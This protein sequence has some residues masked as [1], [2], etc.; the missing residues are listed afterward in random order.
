MKMKLKNMKMKKII[1]IIVIVIIIVLLLQY[2]IYVNNYKISNIDQKKINKIS[3]RLVIKD[4]KSIG[5]K[6]S[7]DYY[8]YKNVKF[9]NIL[10]GFNCENDNNILN[11]KKEKIDFTLK[12]EDSLIT[13]FENTKYK[14]IKGSTILNN[15]NIKDDINLMG[16]IKETK[17]YSPYFKPIKEVKETYFLQKFA[18]NNIKEFNN[19][20]LI[21]TEYE[22][23]IYNIN[24]NIKEYVFT[25]EKL[26][27]SFT[28]K[29]INYFTKS[30]RNE[31]I[32]TL[33]IE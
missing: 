23:Y 30:K 25:K 9:S 7:N 33:I 16:L 21:N 1:K 15:Y 4:I 27:Y 17:N 22:G 26:N 3:D 20:E 14:D 12:I 32:S 28:F 10:E 5:H 11:C 8:E 29:D 19:L 18:L 31:I 13:K 6:D 24:S 2:L